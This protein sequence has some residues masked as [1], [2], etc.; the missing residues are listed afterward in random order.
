MKTFEY[1]NCIHFAWENLPYLQNLS[2]IS[3]HES[4]DFEGF[5]DLPASNLPSWSKLLVYTCPNFQYLT[6]SLP[7]TTLD[8]EYCP[9]S[10]QWD[11]VAQLNQ[12]RY[13]SLIGLN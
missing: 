8:I 12:L 11:V 7:L 6:D 10:K 13:I 1:F 4:I 5:S 9:L 3:V 2:S